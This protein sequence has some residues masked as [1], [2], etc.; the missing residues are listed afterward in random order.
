MNYFLDLPCFSSGTDMLSL[1]SR[2]VLVVSLQQVIINNTSI[3]RHHM[4]IL[5]HLN[6]R[7]SKKNSI[8]TYAYRTWY[9]WHWDIWLIIFQLPYIWFLVYGYWHS[10]SVYGGRQVIAFNDAQGPCQNKIYQWL[11][12]YI[13]PWNIGG[14]NYYYSGY[15]KGSKIT[16][17]Q[18]AW[19]RNAVHHIAKL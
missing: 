2:W 9:W 4:T 12:L 15:T 13:S 1:S 6:I 14:N 19:L 8:T 3:Y 7:F 11:Y 18:L 17:F 16:I 5:V 10:L